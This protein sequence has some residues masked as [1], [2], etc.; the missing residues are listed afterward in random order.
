MTFSVDDLL[1]EVAAQPSSTS[2]ATSS[3]VSATPLEDGPVASVLAAFAAL[4]GARVHTD[5][6]VTHRCIFHGDKRA[7]AVIFE[8]GTYHCSA[9][10]PKALSFRALMETPEARAKLGDNL[11]DAA[12]AVR[13]DVDVP[14]R[15]RETRWPTPLGPAA[16]HG[17]LGRMVRI[18]EPHTESDAAA[19]LLQ[20]LVALG[21]LLGRKV[22]VRV[23][24][25]KHFLVL[26][27]VLVGATSKGRKGTSWDLALDFFPFSAATWKEHRI[28]A[29]LSSG[30]GLIWAV[31]D[32]DP[33][34]HEEESAPPPAPEDK[35]LLVMEPEWARVLRALDREGNTLSAII[36]Q[37]YDSGALRVLTKRSPAVATDVHVSIIAHVTADEFRKCFRDTEAANGFGN[38]FLLACVK[39]S[40]LLPFGGSLR[41]DDMLPIRAALDDVLQFVERL[42]PDDAEVTLGPAARDLWASVYPDLSEGKPGIVGALTARAEAHALRI[43]ALYAVLDQTLVVGRNHLEAALEVVRYAEDST[44]YVF[45]D[46]SGDDVADAIMAALLVRP[47]GMT[48]TELRGYFGRNRSGDE[49]GRAL[50]MLARGGSAKVVTVATAGRSAERWVA[51]EALEPPT[52]KTTETTEAHSEDEPV[53]P[54]VVNVVSVVG[55]AFG[56]KVRAR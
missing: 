6:R 17:V 32:H 25:T 49:I 13:R 2:R 10:L 43:A 30:E 5:G 27:L 56:K 20:A 52:T 44:R 18:A 51:V 29:G 9:C 48:R 40:K 7:S 46:A 41:A 16:Y 33:E 37:C 12:I 35:R 38:R 3:G 4:P 53:P 34:A 22:F 36:R 23:E 26:F 21:N 15:S 1:D 11:V 31:R 39:R 50:D 54:S 45:G 8:H 19:I 14:L 28:L 42:D 47:N 24:R 55:C